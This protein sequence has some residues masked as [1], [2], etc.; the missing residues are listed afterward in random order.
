M[1]KITTVSGSVYLIDETHKTVERFN[2]DVPIVFMNGEVSHRHDGRTSY[3]GWSFLPTLGGDQLYIA[4]P[5]GSYTCSTRVVSVEDD[6][7]WHAAC[8][9][10][11]K[12]HSW[13]GQP[14][15]TKCVD[16][17]AEWEGP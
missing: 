12:D 11:G 2:K 16:C 13:N 6:H 3:L 17:G 10:S 5:D 8:P 15:D 4:Y 1:K 14:F 9:A 7:D